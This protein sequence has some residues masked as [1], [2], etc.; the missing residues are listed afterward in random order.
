MLTQYKMIYRNVLTFQK[1]A[2]RDLESEVDNAESEV[3][4]VEGA[5]AGCM[6]VRSCEPLLPGQGLAQW[7][8]PHSSPVQMN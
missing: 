2:V 3:A 6:W 1:A 4:R 7:P 5:H 8:V